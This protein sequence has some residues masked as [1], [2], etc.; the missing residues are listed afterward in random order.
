M[1]TDYY[2]K[3]ADSSRKVSVSAR[4]VWKICRKMASFKSKSRRW[5][6][7]G[8]EMLFTGGGGWA[9]S[10]TPSVML[11]ERIL[12]A[13]WLCWKKKWQD[14]QVSV[15]IL[16]SLLGALRKHK[17]DHTCPNA[18]TVFHTF[19]ILERTRYES[20]TMFLFKQKL[21]LIMTF[22]FHN[23]L[24]FLVQARKSKATWQ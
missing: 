24:Q 3:W 23:L 5:V 21:S 10:L 7:E 1:S 20:C 4:T 8:K 11:D 18:S 6:E 14:R 16:T 9:C 2:R 22:F 19:H 17:Y 12:D 15:N 13:S